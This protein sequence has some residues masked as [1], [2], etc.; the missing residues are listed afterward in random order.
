MAKRSKQTFR[1]RQRELAKKRKKEA[2]AERLAAR[3]VD[4][5]GED[6]ETSVENDDKVADSRMTGEG[7]ILKIRLVGS[8]NNE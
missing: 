7:K 4:K 8:K 5:T 3:R 2:K 6:D 1:K